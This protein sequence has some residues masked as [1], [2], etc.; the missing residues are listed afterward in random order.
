MYLQNQTLRKYALGNFGEMANAMLNDG[1]LQFWLD[2][3][4]NTAK[5]AK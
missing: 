4:E 2:G 5:V 3:G 1:A